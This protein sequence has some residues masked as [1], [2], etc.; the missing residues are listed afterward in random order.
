[1]EDTINR[2]EARNQLLENKVRDQEKLIASQER[3]IKI[4]RPQVEG[5]QD[6]VR[7]LA[8][9]RT[10]LGTDSGYGFDDGSNYYG[11]RVA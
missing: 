6:L 7:L 2:A 9:A 5:K 10:L 11:G 8:D 4:L 1:M 3:E